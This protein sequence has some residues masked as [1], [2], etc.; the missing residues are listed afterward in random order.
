M[1]RWIRP[2]QNGEWA[3]LF[4]SF[5]SSAFRLEG[6]QTYASEVEDTALKRFLAGQPHGV[7]L[8]WMTSK[9]A[10]HITA[11]R[12][13]T[14]VRVVVEPPTDYTRLELEIYPE[15]VAAGQDTR[16]IG[17]ASGSW[18]EDVPRHD[19]WLFDERDLWRMHY[20]DDHTWAGAELL[21]DDSVVADHLRWRDAALAQSV[22]LED[23]LSARASLNRS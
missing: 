19:Y 18:P 16:I 1:N 8:S 10:A 3:D 21:S 23:Y 6:Q 15:F 20:R 14:L 9:L 22:P 2:G 12:T 5:T 11:G 7:D 13:Q 4:T 17:V